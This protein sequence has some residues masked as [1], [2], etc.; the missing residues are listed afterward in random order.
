MGLGG[1]VFISYDAEGGSHHAHWIADRLSEGAT[2][3]QCWLADL[4][5]LDTDDPILEVS[6]AIQACSCFI[7]VG[8]KEVLERESRAAN[9]WRLALK[10]KKT[11]VVAVVETC[12][13]PPHLDRRLQVS[14]DEQQPSNIDAL[15]DA[16]LTAGTTQGR[17]ASAKQYLE[18]AEQARA[19]AL[20]GN[21]ARIEA[22]ILDQK[23]LVQALSEVISDPVG[24][25]ER[26]NQRVR[27]GVERERVPQHALQNVDEGAVKIRFIN[28]APVLAPGYFQDRFVETRVICEFLR[29]E[30]KRLL[31]VTGRGG[32]GKSA[33]V[34]RTL[35]GLERGI[36]P[37][38]NGDLRIRGIVYLSHITQRRPSFD[39][40][41]GDLL[42]LLPQDKQDYLRP[43]LENSEVSSGVK[44]R[45]L[46]AA[47]TGQK[48]EPT[49][50]LLDNMEDVIDGVSFQIVDLG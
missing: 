12:H 47:F 42:L 10:Y 46:L 25:R 24:V 45:E 43:I 7:L 3:I 11:I 8:T 4:N 48:S 31:V 20:P 35:R 29:D 19:Y 22:D 18:D 5:L 36:L 13:W 14:I 49:V 50:V 32:V 17:L 34:C 26:L 6:A 40:L 1:L 44:A 9:E 21:R 15:R 30:A 16:I 41:C 39:N 2:P 27:L 23:R 37:D 33:L 38:E 28:P